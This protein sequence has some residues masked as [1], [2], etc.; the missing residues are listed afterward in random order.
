MGKSEN[1]KNWWKNRSPETQASPKIFW[2]YPTLPLSFVESCRHVGM[3]T[4]GLFC[5]IC[6]LFC[7]VRHF[8]N[9]CFV[10][11]CQKLLRDNYWNV[12]G[13]VFP[14]VFGWRF[15]GG[16]GCAVPWESPLPPGSPTIGGTGIPCCEC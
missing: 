4:Y 3:I 1:A 13:W 2:G 14:V 7:F 8:A 12:F 15:I 10:L 5:D 9:H 6:C 16:E 11:G